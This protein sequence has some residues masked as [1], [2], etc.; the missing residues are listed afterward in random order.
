MHRIAIKILSGNRKGE[1]VIS[2]HSP[3]QCQG[4]TS[5]MY[6]VVEDN[7]LHGCKWIIRRELTECPV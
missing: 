2:T 1:I 6:K 5:E 3:D 7:E 4:R